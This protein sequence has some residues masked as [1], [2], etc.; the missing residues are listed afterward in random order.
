MNA[1]PR[2]LET[3]ETKDSIVELN[4]DEYNI[5]KGQFGKYFDVPKVY[6]P[7]VTITPK[8]Y[9]GLFHVGISLTIIVKPKIDFAN[10]VGMLRYVD[11]RRVVVWK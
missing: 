4:L 8:F 7:Q 10:F 5:I 11:S 9:I 6:S 2:V 3:I 1:A